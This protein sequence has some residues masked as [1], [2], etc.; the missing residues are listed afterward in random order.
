[1]SGS[2]P[3]TDALSALFIHVIILSKFPRMQSNLKYY[4]YIPPIVL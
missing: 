1:M 2:V 4:K 3:D